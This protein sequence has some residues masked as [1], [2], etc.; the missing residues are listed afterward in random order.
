MSQSTNGKQVELVIDGNSVQAPAGSHVLAAALGNGIDIPHLCYHPELSVSGGCRLC[1]VEVEGRSDPVPS[2][3]LEV[4]DGMVISTQTERLRS[5]RRD[6][7]DLFISDHPLDCVVCDKAGS[8]SLQDLAYEYGI[9]E[10]SYPFPSD[11]TLVQEDNPFFLR[12]HPYCIQCGRCIRVCDEVIGASAIDF[13]NRGIEVHVA[14]PFDEPM[15]DS[16]CVFCGTCVELCPTAA[17]LPM[18]RRGNGREWQLDRVRSV[19]GYCGVGCEVEYALHDGAILYARGGGGT[20]VNGP[21]LCTK[22][23]YGWDFAQHEERLTQPLMRRDTAHSLGLTEEPWELPERSPLKNRRPDIRESHVPVSWDQALG[24]VADQLAA[25]I[26]EDGPDSVMGLASARCSNE[27]NYLFQ[28][29]MRAGVG[30]NNLD[31]CAR[32]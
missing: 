32:L 19:C 2:C 27:E 4:A 29:L 28:K 26:R 15:A 18:A 3:G 21:T 8:C 6:V 5:L 13:V 7:L 17:L 22:G 12:D 1:L 25:I 9:R 14:T 20:S 31:H 11:R 16:T 23:R 30:T 24:W 10:S